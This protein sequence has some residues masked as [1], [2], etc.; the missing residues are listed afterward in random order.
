MGRVAISIDGRL[1]AIVG[2][3]RIQ[4]RKWIGKFPSNLRFRLGL[5][6]VPLLGAAA[7]TGCGEA[8]PAITSQEATAVEIHRVGDLGVTRNF[9]AAGTV[10]LRRETPLAFLTDGRIRTIDVREGDEVRAGQQLA[11]LDR[12]AIDASA[13]AADTRA[14]QTASEAL[15]Q[16]DLYKKGWVTKSRVES[17]DATAEAARAEQSSARFAQRFATITAPSAGMIL[18]RLAEPGQT[19]AAGTP[20]LVLGEYSSGFV[21][22][23]RLSA[24][25]VAGIR[26][27]QSAHITFRDGAAP[28]TTGRIVEISG[29]ADPRTGTFQVELALPANPALRSGQI[30]D[31]GLA[32]S[33]AG[34]TIVIP[35]TSLFAA[36]AD[37]GF[38]WRFDRASETATAQMVRLGAVTGSGIEVASGLARGDLIVAS[39]VDRIVA[40][41]KLKVIAPKSTS[42]AAER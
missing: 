35:S 23:V 21:L 40:G 24:A 19:I 17:A 25:Q 14:R 33:G 28:S 31:V 42:V 39:G 9:V 38:V 8:P 20:A 10:R 16:Q 41:Q 32:A 37:E 2:I 15:R 26:S 12:T 11:Q 30:A 34:D 7:L 22:R 3:C 18:Q 5:L 1:S 29:R 13:I 36:R 6:C 27:G 4:G